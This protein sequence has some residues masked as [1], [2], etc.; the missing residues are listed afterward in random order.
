M[1]RLFYYITHLKALINR[2]R[3]TGKNPMQFKVKE[4][5][6]YDVERYI[7]YAGIFNTEKKD[8]LNEIKLIMNK[9]KSFLSTFN[10]CW[11]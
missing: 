10:I 6:K 4:A 8:K 7:R 1:K 11:G 9:A 3:I 2:L 5:M